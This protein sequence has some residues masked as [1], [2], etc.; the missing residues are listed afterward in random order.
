[1]HTE[2]HRWFA[3]VNALARY[4]IA[5]LQQGFFRRQEILSRREDRYII[6]QPQGL[7]GF[8][9]IKDKPFVSRLGSDDT[10]IR[11]DQG[12]HK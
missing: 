5:E 7:G 1:M 2:Q 4:P 8:K 9:I 3:L 11:L 10:L 6:I 12:L